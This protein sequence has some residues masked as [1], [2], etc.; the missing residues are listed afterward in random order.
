MTV[1]G[2]NF[3]R[4]VCVMVCVHVCYGVVCC[5][6]EVL[7][8]DDDPLRNKYGDT[9]ER[10]IVQFVPMAKFMHSNSALVSICTPAL[11]VSCWCVL[12]F[13]CVNLKPLPFHFSFTSQ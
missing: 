5:V 1:L 11:I 8:A 10:D 12:L 7:D 2:V 9:M 6:Q 13:V 3:S 4:G